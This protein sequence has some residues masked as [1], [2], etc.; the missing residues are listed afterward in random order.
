M[1]ILGLNEFLTFKENLTDVIIAIV[2]I[3]TSYYNNFV[4]L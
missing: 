4:L 1:P 3:P 2:S